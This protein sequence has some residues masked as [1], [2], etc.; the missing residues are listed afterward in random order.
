MKKDKK[1]LEELEACLGKSKYKDEIISKYDNLIKSEKANGKRIKYILKDLG[2]PSEIAKLE[3]ESY[4]ANKS[5]I[6]KSMKE[7]FASF[8]LKKNNKEKK[9]KKEK[10]KKNKKK[11]NKEKKIR[12]KRKLKKKRIKIK[13][14]LLLKKDLLS[15]KKLLL[16]I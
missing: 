5:N 6:F 4:K 14:K 3:L 16:V 1:F 7:K 12:K 9:E 13:R 2:E 15:L 11:E 8:K 10:E